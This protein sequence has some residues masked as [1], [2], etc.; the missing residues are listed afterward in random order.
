LDIFSAVTLPMPLRFLRPNARLTFPLSLCAA[1]LT[2]WTAPVVAADEQPASEAAESE[3]RDDDAVRYNPNLTAPTLGGRQFWGDVCYFHD[4]RI[5]QCVPTG[6]Y[7][8]L[9]GD[10][11]RHAWGTL[12]QCQAKLHEIRRVRQLA[13]MSGE[14]VILIHGI[15]RSSQS[16]QAL[17]EAIA[18][19]MLYEG[20][21]SC[22]TFG[23]DYPS[24][25][26]GIDESA[27]YLHR[28]IESLEGIERIHFVTHSMGGLVVRAY[29]A[30][31]A[32][33]RLGRLVMI[34]TPNQWA[35][36]A[37][38]L[39]ANPLFKL[40]LGPSGQQLPADPEGFIARLP[41][42]EMEFGI[43]AGGRGD[44][45]GYNPLLPGDD[46]GTVSVACTK[47]DGAADFVVVDRL[48]TFIVRAPET[49]DYALRF[50]K[51]GRFEPRKETP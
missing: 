27:E 47:L 51:D 28:V 11:Y 23:F 35:E 21:T 7:R 3:R 5:Q 10:N 1:L 29:L 15:A 25:R 43:I 6:H 4:W 45:R 46:D 31:H 34:A 42:P 12:E 38:L 19:E 13:P 33:P 18:D 14:A 24:T 40:I 22:H 30:K 48:H 32:E 41:V 37:T 16:M 50:L 39:K 17:R 8:L 49:R 9:D 20:K 2:R 44:E 36:L 26:V